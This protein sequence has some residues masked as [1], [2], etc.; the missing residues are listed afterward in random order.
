MLQIVAKNRKV[1]VLPFQLIDEIKEFTEVK[2]I[3]S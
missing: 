3:Q 2:D 1:L